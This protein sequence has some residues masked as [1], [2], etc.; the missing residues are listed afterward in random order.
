MKS[1]IRRINNI[2]QEKVPEKPVKHKLLFEE[3]ERDVL[4]EKRDKVRKIRE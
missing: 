1:L 3:E 4:K 2:L